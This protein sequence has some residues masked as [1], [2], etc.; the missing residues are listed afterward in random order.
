MGNNLGLNKCSSTTSLLLSF[1]CRVH[2][3]FVFPFS[4]FVHPHHLPL[5][6]YFI[7][8]SALMDTSFAQK[9]PWCLSGCQWWFCSLQSPTCPWALRPPWA[10]P[11]HNDQMWPGPWSLCQLRTG[12]QPRLVGIPPPHTH[13]HTQHRG[14]ETEWGEGQ[15]WVVVWEEGVICLCACMCVQEVLRAQVKTAWEKG[16]RLSK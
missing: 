8:N 9:I 1:M 3:W 16:W 2:T 6:L 4:L 11:S 7:S 10:S 12:G 5:C 15:R 13:I 14:S